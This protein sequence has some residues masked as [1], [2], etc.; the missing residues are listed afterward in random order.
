MKGRSRGRP[1]KLILIDGKL[2]SF[3]CR[4]SQHDTCANITR[5]CECDC[6]E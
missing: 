6:H 5:E 2:K 3:R 1:M 4:N